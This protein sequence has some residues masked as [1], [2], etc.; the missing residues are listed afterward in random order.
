MKYLIEMYRWFSADI[1][2]FTWVGI[3]IVVIVIVVSLYNDAEHYITSLYNGE[4]PNDP[5]GF[6]KHPVLGKDLKEFRDKIK[7]KK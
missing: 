6:D 3:A 5:T 7:E 2:T 1:G 4:D